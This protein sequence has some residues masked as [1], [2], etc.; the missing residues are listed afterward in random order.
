MNML[1]KL[2]AIV[3]CAVH[4]DKNKDRHK[5]T[6]FL[7]EGIIS[8]FLFSLIMIIVGVIGLAV[9]SYFIW[10][11]MVIPVIFLSY[12]YLNRYFFRYDHYLD[13]VKVTNQYSKRKKRLYA[14]V[15]IFLF[16][17]AGA[18]TIGGGMLMSYLLSLH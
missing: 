16:I 4:E 7:I 3:Y 10:A 5:R 18:Q 17:L 1:D 11:L 9:D 8:F 14:F 12:F 13:I 6:V 15:A 2:F